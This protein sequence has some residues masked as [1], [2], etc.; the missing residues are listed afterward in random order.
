VQSVER[1]NAYAVWRRL[2]PA[3]RIKTQLDAGLKAS[4]TKR[5][6]YETKQSAINGTR[7]SKIMPI[8]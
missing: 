6:R 2:K 1:S 3:R 5:L 4:S 7:L 8:L